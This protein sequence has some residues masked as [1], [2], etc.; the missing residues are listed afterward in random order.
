M[1]TAF[2][3]RSTVT[4]AEAEGAAQPALLWALV[5]HG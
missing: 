5:E 1:M 3:G 4:P 2:D